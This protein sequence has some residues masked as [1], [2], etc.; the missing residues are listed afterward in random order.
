MGN[1][2]YVLVLSLVCLLMCTSLIQA[3]ETELSQITYQDNLYYFY[4][5]LYDRLPDI[6]SPFTT[7][8]GTEILIAV[9]K[10]G[11][12]TVIPV[13]VE[14][15]APLN[16][17]QG[18]RGKGRQLEVD[19]ADFPILARIGLHAEVELD[20]TKTITGKSIGEITEIGR[21]EMSSGAGFV[22]FDEDIIS[23]LKGDNRLVQKLE[24]THP[25]LA[26]P[27]FHVWNIIRRLDE[28]SRLRRTTLENI[29]SF[30]YNGKKIFLSSGSGHGWQESIFNDEILGMWQLEMWRILDEQEVKFLSEKF[31]DLSTEQM[32]KLRKKLSSIHTGEMVPYYIMR[33]GFYEGH[34]SYRADPL[35]I[36]LV[37]GLK[38]IEEIK[39]S[40][41]GDLYKTLTDR[42]TR[43]NVSSGE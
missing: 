1:K 37:F 24:L 28:E 7:A 35:A 29:D 31:P 14:N 26:K 43:E 34:T 21:P 42:Y 32:A 19:T 9:T 15:G 12:Y 13:T 16:Y 3:Q 39:N 23:V 5:Q 25:Q 4:P 27:L 10:A 18:Q 30:Y 36:S 2:L 20:Q 38:S 22:E 40:L 17:K 6:P 8:D 11:K 41:A 33:Y